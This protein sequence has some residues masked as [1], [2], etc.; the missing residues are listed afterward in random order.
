MNMNISASTRKI[1][2]RSRNKKC[3][4]KIPLWKRYFAT[5]KEQNIKLEHVYLDK[6]KEK[7]I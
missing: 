7:S 5:A 6:S 4:D 2:G 1:R 3:A